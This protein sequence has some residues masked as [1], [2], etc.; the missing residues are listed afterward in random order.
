MDL[1]ARNTPHDCSACGDGRR[2]EA[3]CERRVFGQ[4][5][6]KPETGMDKPIGSVC[7]KVDAEL[8]NETA[9][10]GG[11]DQLGNSLK[12][13]HDA[14]MSKDRQAPA[15]VL[16]DGARAADIMKMRIHDGHDR[17]VGEGSQLTEGGAHLFDGFTR[18]NGDETIGSL[19]KGLVGQAIA[20][21]APDARTGRIKPAFEPSAVL[22]EKAVGARARL[23]GDNIAA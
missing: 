19:N 5:E 11:A 1:K 20:N 7:R 21:E 14:F 15:G 8:F 9:A 16:E 2:L 6:L 4:A 22:H 10:I 17:T 3:G 23:C 18:I 13:G 12:V